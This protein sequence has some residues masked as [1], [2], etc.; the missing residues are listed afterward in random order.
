MTKPY[1]ERIF[2]FAHDELFQAPHAMQYLG[3]RGVTLDQAKELRLG[4]VPDDKWPPYFDPKT[5]SPEEIYYLDKSKN[6]FR[7]KG[8]LMFPLT[9]AMGQL[10]G[11]QIRSPNSEVKDYWKFYGLKSDIDALFFG[12]DA[13]MDYIWQTREVVLVEGIFDLFPVQRVF[14]NTL[15]T[16]TA[17]LSERQKKFLLRYVDH[18]KVVFDND[19]YGESF[20]STFYRN[21]REDFHSIQKIPYIGKD[22]SASWLRLGEDKFKAQFSDVEVNGRTKS[23]Y[24]ARYGNA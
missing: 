19:E 1:L 6:G 15:C 23:L 11:F 9:N 17:N 12:T 7:L 5:A 3:S 13:A 20:F 4:Y 24:S 2:D 16:G 18:V 10:R 21:H 22:P 8:K 14:P